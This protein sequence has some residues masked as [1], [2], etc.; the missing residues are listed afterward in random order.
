[1]KTVST[2]IAN[3]GTPGYAREAVSL[4]TAVSARAASSG[5]AVG[6]PSRIAD[7]VSGGHRLRSRGRRRVGRTP[8]RPISTG[9]QSLLGRAGLR[10]AAFPARMDAI[11]AAATAMTGF[12]NSPQ[13]V[14]NF[15]RQV[16]DAIASLQ[17][18]GQDAASGAGGC[19]GR[20]SAM[21]S[22]A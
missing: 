9:L 4:T 10:K 3:V 17:Q 6:E 14:G 5:V 12:S 13:T 7:H 20:R 18:L 22:T 21:M 1:L 19:R 16:E 8:R 11:S 15:V 2:N